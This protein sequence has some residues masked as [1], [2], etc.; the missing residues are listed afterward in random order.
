MVL[1]STCLLGASVC[2]K[3]G[4]GDSNGGRDSTVLLGMSL[5]SINSLR[6]VSRSLSTS[7]TFL[8]AEAGASLVTLL[9]A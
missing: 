3:G 4:G 6:C 1:P 5:N 2:G 9:V 8:P 7:F